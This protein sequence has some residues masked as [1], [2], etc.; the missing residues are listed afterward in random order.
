MTET[1][2]QEV[3]QGVHETDQAHSIG[4]V[5]VRVEHREI[6]LFL[7]DGRREK[8]KTESSSFFLRAHS[9]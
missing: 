7:T 5:E 4:E 9:I 6:I 1:E 3:M 2:E 8:Q